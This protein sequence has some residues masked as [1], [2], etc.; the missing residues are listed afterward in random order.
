MMVSTIKQ[1]VHPCSKLYEACV[2]AL[3]LPPLTCKPFAKRITNHLIV[4]VLH[5]LKLCRAYDPETPFKVQQD[6]IIHFL[7]TS[8][9][10]PYRPVQ[11]VVFYL[12]IL[13]QNLKIMR[14]L[15]NARYKLHRKKQLIT[16]NPTPET[17]CPFQPNDSTDLTLE[18][19]PEF[20]S[21]DDDDDD[22]PSN[23]LPSIFDLPSVDLPSIIDLPS[24]DLSSIDLPS[25][26]LPSIDLPP[27]LPPDLSSIDFPYL[28]PQ[29]EPCCDRNCNP[30]C[31]HKYFTSTLGVLGPS[32][33]P[34]M[35]SLDF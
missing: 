22:F 4:V 6:K 30:P 1:P 16:L 29:I 10:P 7:A 14:S 20:P 27:D 8:P 34:S 13:I 24:I 9:S 23:D 26:D 35:S 18:S 15:R 11:L 33:A 17:K 5:W 21:I 3:A 2:F 32:S 12:R 31:Y 19:C 25:I 28:L